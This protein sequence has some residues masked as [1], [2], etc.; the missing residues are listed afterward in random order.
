M[1]KLVNLVLELAFISWASRD[2]LLFAIGYHR[3]LGAPNVKLSKAFCNWGGV[4]TAGSW[5]HSPNLPRSLVF[6]S[7][8]E[9]VN[10]RSVDS[11]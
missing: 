1:D 5:L 9:T 7:S 2:D 10:F 3:I 8:L 6:S 4:G 11:S